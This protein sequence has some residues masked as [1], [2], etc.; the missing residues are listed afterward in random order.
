MVEKIGMKST[1]F[2]FNDNI[3]ARMAIGI[4]S[5]VSN[6]VSNFVFI[7]QGYNAIPFGQKE[8]STN[9]LELGWPSPAGNIK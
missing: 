7:R 2:I 9:F 3:K 5:E 1:G 6:S 8:D 4:N